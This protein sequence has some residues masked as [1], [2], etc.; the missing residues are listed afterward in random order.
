MAIALGLGQGGTAFP[1]FGIA[2]DGVAV[3]DVGAESGAPPSSLRGSYL[4]TR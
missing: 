4:R 2:P 1:R 3:L